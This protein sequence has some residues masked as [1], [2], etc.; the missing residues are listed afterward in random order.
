MLKNETITI[1]LSSSE[2]RWYKN[3]GYTIPT[4]KVQLWATKNGKQI[5]NGTKTRVA[6]GTKLIVK[7]NDLHP[8]S[9]R[10]IKLIC[11]DCK[12]EYQTTY[13]AYKKKRTDKCKICQKKM[14]KGDGSHGYWVNKLITNN[15]DVKCDICREKD[16][17]FLELHHLLSV[18][19]GG[20]NKE[21]NYVVLSANYHIAFHRY[22]GTQNPS[23]K[24]EY[25]KFKENNKYY[26]N[27]IFSEI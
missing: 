17:R 18:K 25:Y 22:I 19:L 12:N 9:N 8:Q 1:T 21:D 15:P 10:I 2:I 11:E 13:G 20:R 5:K 4:H 14:L 23:T 24:E 26:D 16:K 6:N 27:L 7:I 3:K